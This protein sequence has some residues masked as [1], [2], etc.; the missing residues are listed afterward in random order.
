VIEGSLKLG[1]TVSDKYV[2]LGFF[3]LGTTQYD[4][5]TD[6]FSNDPPS[7]AWAEDLFEY[8]RK[9]AKKL[10]LRELLDSK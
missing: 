4:T 8:F 2:S 10:D 9:D 6:L 7:V 3:K 1:L 5:S